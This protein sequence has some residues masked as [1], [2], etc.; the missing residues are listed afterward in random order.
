MTKMKTTKSALVLSIVSLFLCFT[1]LIGTT[2]AWFTDSVTSAGNKIMSGTLQVDLEL[3]DKDNGAWNSIKEDKTA[4]FNNDKW[5]PGYTEVKMLKVENEGTLA[6][7]WKAKFVAEKELSILA[8]VIDVYVLPYGVLDDASAVAYPA[9]R[10]LDGYTK[11][12]TLREFV[13]TIETTTYG[14]LEAGESAYLGLA[15]KMQENAGNEYQGLDLGG[16]FDIMILATQL[17]SESDSFDNQYDADADFVTYDFV[18]NSADE[19][20]AAFATGGNI[21]LDSDIELNEAIVITEETYLNLND[22]VLTVMGM[23]F[24][25]GATIKDGTIS[26]GGNTYLTTHIKVSGGILNM[27][28]VTVDVNHHLNANVN[29][30][31]ATGMEIQNATATLNNCNIKIDNPTGAKWVY[32]YGIS[33]NNAT[34]TINGGSITAECEE[35]TAANGPTNP[36]AISTMGECTVTLNNVDVEATYYAT[37]VNGHLTINT[38]DTSVMDA[39]IVDNRGGSHTLNYID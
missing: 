25:A 30:T 26:S 12:G 29:W 11:V 22:N 3:L 23:D 8:D 39:D 7:K 10:N 1:M 6:L 19:L 38:T 9:D 20:K 18:V 2:F 37:T 15:L 24:Q 36:N 17:D 27:D 13:N 21:L 14:N 28:T 31:E 32:S 34:V 5:E 35:G 33:L 16:V 4:L